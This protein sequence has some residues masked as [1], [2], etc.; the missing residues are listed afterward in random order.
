MMFGNMPSTSTTF[1][2]DLRK[3]KRRR[4]I[5]NATHSTKNTLIRHEITAMMNVCMNIFGKFRMCV[6]VN[7][8]M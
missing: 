3:R 5:E 4:L 2:K 6:S 7:S 1:M 8:W